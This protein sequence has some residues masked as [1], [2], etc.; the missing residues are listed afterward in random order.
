MQ[1]S[2]E[3]QVTQQYTVE[4]LLISCVEARP[5]LWDSRLPLKDRSKP[6]RDNLWLEIFAE[7]GSNPEFTIEFLIKKWRNLRDTFVRIKGEYT[8]SGS[9]CQKKKKWEYF[10][11]L[12]FLNDTV[13]YRPT[14]SNVKLPECS[15]TPTPLTSP[16]FVPQNELNSELLLSSTKKKVLDKAVEG[17]IIQALEKVNATPIITENRP[18]INPICC[19]ISSLLDKIPEREKTLLEIKLLQTTY[20]VAKPYLD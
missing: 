18:T 14:I 5:P 19:R 1:D 4:E 8:P 3:T 17:A 12:Q 6:I 13:K 16:E 20:E 9:A 7:F 10:D 2:E 11:S 15:K